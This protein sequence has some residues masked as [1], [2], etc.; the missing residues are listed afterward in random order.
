MNTIKIFFLMFLMTLLFI[1]VGNL[2]GGTQGMI[3]ALIFAFFMN[4]ITYW[5]SSSIVLKMYGAREVTEEEAPEF[6]NLVKEVAMQ[7]NLPMPKVAIIPQDAP[8]AF[9]T[10]RNHH[11]AV[12]AATEGI[13]KLLSREELK[14]V[15]AHE[16]AHIKNYDM[17]IGTIAATFAA[18]MAILPRMFLFFGGGRDRDRNPLGAI[19]ALVGMIVLPIVALLIR[20][21]ISRAGEYRADETG[22][23]FI[24]NPQALA[25]ALA[26]LHSYSQRIPLQGN[27]ATAHMFI[28]NPFS[29]K[30][31]INLF[32]THPP[33]EERINRLKSL[34]IR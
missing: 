27:E 14:G 23:R 24:K 32:S 28:V 29:G 10:G 4:F 17:L 31:L 22:A 12:V 19:L 15:I 26:K 9:A 33:I 5:F 2:L 30:S 34:E 6:Y 8:N 3:T 16:F 13:L 18:A 7:A 20:M 1:F 11:N 21:A 25:S